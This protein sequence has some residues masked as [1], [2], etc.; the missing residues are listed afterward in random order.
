MNAH[1][2]WRDPSQDGPCIAWARELFGRLAPFATG[3]VYVNFMPD[4]ERQ[5]VRQGAYGPNYERLAQLKARYD[6]DNLFRYNQN[7]APA[8]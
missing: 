1:T 5:R 2:R 4:D 3:G 6:P 8:P 7:I